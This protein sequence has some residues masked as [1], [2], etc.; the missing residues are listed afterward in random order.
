MEMRLNGKAA[1]MAH[2]GSMTPVNWRAW[3]MIKLRYGRVIY[4]KRACGKLPR[5]WALSEE[6]DA[7]DREQSVSIYDREYASL[8]AASDTTKHPMAFAKRMQR[9]A[10]ELVAV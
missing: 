8:V 9:E 3:T 4:C 10:R 2:V 5:Y 6:M 7:I 1:I